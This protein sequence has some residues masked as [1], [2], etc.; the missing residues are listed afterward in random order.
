MAFGPLLILACSLSFA[1]TGEAV[2]V[3]ENKPL[4]PSSARAVEQLKSAEP[5]ERWEATKALGDLGPEVELA[6]PALIEA[7]KSEQV[8]GLRWGY[9]W[10]LG[11]IGP[12]APGVVDALAE[13][14]SDPD[15]HV[16]HEAATALGNMGRAARSALP[17]LEAARGDRNSVV[18]EAIEVAI[19]SVG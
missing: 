4:S 5:R 14:L 13:A 3:P 12:A 6:A 16:R 1:C 17:A 7:L 11:Q 15:D 2:L 8:P 19:Q 10:A 18:D 9:V